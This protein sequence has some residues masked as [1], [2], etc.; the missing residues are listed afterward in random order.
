M[1]SGITFLGV[2][3]IGVFGAL[4]SVMEAKRSDG[5]SAFFN[6]LGMIAMIYFASTLIKFSCLA[7]NGKIPTIKEILPTP[8]ETLR[9]TWVSLDIIL[10]YVSVHY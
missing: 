9:F 5:G 4:A 1:Y 7:L 6:I 3:V 10:Q 8:K 2:V